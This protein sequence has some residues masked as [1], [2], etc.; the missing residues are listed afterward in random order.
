MDSF[1]RSSMRSAPSRVGFGR[2]ARCQA[3][4]SAACARYAPRPPLRAI[5]RNTVDAGRPSPA[6]IVRF[7]H[8]TAIPR[9]I[10]SRPVPDSCRSG[11]R[12]AGGRT[13]P[14]AASSC[15]TFA[16]WQPSD[17]AISL[18]GSPLPHRL[19][20]SSI[21]SAEN[22]TSTSGWHHPLGGCVDRLRPP[23]FSGLTTSIRDRIGSATGLG[24]SLGEEPVEREGPI[25]ETRSLQ[26]RI[27]D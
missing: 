18:L 9:E 4:A 2:R 19:H 3:A 24:A 26:R 11:R 7:V 21:C 1:G 20:N 8:P 13:P 6:P 10:S 12:R 17:R 23:S 15:F 27:A 25:A 16:A 5:S 22:L 14:E